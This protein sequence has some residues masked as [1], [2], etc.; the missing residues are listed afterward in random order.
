[1]QGLYITLSFYMY[2][3]IY[4]QTWYT[5]T[6]KPFNFVRHLIL[7]IFPYNTNVLPYITDTS[8][9]ISHEHKNVTICIKSRIIKVMRYTLSMGQWFF[10]NAF[11]FRR[12][13]LVKIFCIERRSPK[14]HSFTKWLGDSNKFSAMPKCLHHLWAIYIKICH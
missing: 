9:E 6:V 14:K 7:H 2:C 4:T 1:M 12:A 5:G 8:H 3:S 13:G 10:V 11:N